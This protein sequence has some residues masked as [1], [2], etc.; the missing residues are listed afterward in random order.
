MKVV[1]F[2]RDTYDSQRLVKKM[3]NN[4]ESLLVW[5]IHFRPGQISENT[6]VHTSC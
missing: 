1:R 6:L 4:T 3:T 2:A 5:F